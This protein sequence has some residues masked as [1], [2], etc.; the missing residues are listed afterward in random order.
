MALFVYL[1]ESGDT[2]FRFNK[3]SSRYFVITL[4]LV[5]DPVPF[6]AAVA[7]LRKRLGFADGN[8][9]KF[10]SASHEV[11]MAFM[12]MLRR[13]DF[14]A[15]TL[16]IDKT[17]MTRPHLQKRETFYSY[18]VKLILEHDHGTIADAMLILDQSVKSK[19]SKQ[20]L[21]TY[22]R[23][24][25]NAERAVPKVRDI[26]YHDSRSDDLIQAIDMLAGAV[27]SRY[28]KGHEAYLD[29]IRAKFSDI[30]V[31]KPYRAQ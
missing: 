12:R 9:F 22:L 16:V 28:H 26:R 5:D 31:W 14:R 2:G 4:L 18:L 8:E 15:R 1:D 13:Q 30:W 24:A 25:L 29:E 10:Y 6:A 21:A 11:R 17:L 19:K 20:Q 23:R 7:D 27:Y 3:G